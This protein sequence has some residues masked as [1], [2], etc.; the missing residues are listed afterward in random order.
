M[1]DGVAP[2]QSLGGTLDVPDDLCAA[3]AL[4]D[5]SIVGG[6]GRKLVRIDRDGRRAAVL[7]LDNVVGVARGPADTLILSEGDN[8]EGDALKLWWPATRELTHV[9]PKLLELDDRPMF[10]Y[11][12]ASA[13]LVVA[14]RPR[15]WHALA[16]SEL[17]ALRRVSED[18][19]T[20]RRAALI[21]RPSRGPG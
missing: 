16:W 9:P 7:P 3:V 20:A 11:F 10:V 5:G 17:E 15:M 8:P 19:F 14:A 21:E 6:F 13:Q 18:E 1:W 4:S 12:D 2:P